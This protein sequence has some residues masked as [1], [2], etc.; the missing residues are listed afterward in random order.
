MAAAR[1]GETHTSFLALHIP[2]GR[3]W[4][5]TTAVAELT[6]RPSSKRE[7]YAPFFSLPRPLPL[8]ALPLPSIAGHQPTHDSGAR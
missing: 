5:H 6:D 4:G 3:A 2:L 7:I 1:Y 8:P